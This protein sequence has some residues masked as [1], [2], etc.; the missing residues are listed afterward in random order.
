V[1]N[2]EFLW[3]SITNTARLEWTNPVS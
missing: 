2:E 1:G 3:R